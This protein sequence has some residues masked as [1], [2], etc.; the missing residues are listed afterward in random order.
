V[1]SSTEHKKSIPLHAQGRVFA[2]RSK[3][4]VVR[5][6]VEDIERDYQNN[7]GWEIQNC[8]EIELRLDSIQR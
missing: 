4:I 3:E 2:K 6:H 8:Y 1:N 7:H 5:Q